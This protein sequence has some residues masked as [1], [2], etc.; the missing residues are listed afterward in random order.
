MKDKVIR[1]SFY[2]ITVYCYVVYCVLHSDV[3]SVFSG[4]LAMFWELGN[5]LQV[6]QCFCKY[7]CTVAKFLRKG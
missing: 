5:L 6:H 2:I 3:Q 4:G 1:D 7:S